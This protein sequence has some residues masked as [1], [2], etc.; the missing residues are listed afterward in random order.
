MLIATWNVNSIRTRID[1][2][3]NWLE[4][5]DPDL[6]CLQ[7]TKVEDISFPEKLFR[8]MG[9]KII[10]SGQKS[11]NGVALISRHPIEDIKIG[12]NSVLKNDID[13]IELS[14]Q[15]RI[16]NATVNDIKVINVYVPNGSSL[17]SDKFK[18]KIKWLKCLKR[19]LQKEL[20]NGVPICLL[21][22]FNIAPEDKDIHNPEK[23]SGG[24]MASTDERKCLKELL[25]DQLED[26]FRI[27]ESENNHWSWWNYQHA[28]WERNR[29][30]RID[31][32]YLTEE[33]ISNCTS[34]FIDKEMRGKDKPSDHAPVMVD[35]RWPPDSNDCESFFDV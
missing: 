16:I 32:I 12:F 20:K 6:L 34:C 14:E 21:G 1:H 3:K 5:N 29:G 24:I 30:W 33:L 28:S 15:K 35:I 4:N 11:Y 19:Y 10:F 31:H 26:V 22:D 17:T 18:Y 13:A 25:N 27:F 2:I 8:E 7:E 23:H 9:Y